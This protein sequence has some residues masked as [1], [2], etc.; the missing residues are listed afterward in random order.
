M[1]LCLLELVPGPVVLHIRRVCCRISSVHTL[2]CH[3]RQRRDSYVCI[4]KLCLRIA[5]RC[6]QDGHHDIDLRSS[7]GLVNVWMSTK[8]TC[9]KTLVCKN[10][11]ILLD[12]TL[13]LSKVMPTR[14][15]YFINVDRAG[16]FFSASSPPI[17][18]ILFQRIGQKGLKKETDLQEIN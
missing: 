5:V 16:N 17:W 4:A 10:K 15:L 3:R 11:D 1:L 7:P 2:Q 18:K 14:V 8:T 12:R 6:C 9:G 13:T